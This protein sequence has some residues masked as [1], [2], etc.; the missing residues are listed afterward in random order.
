MA[1]LPGTQLKAARLSTGQLERGEIYC[2]QSW[3]PG[4]AEL[5]MEDSASA[6]EGAEFQADQI[7]LQAAL[8]MGQPQSGRGRC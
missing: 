2:W 6:G 5:G 7:Q 1:A 8:E 3:P 4:S